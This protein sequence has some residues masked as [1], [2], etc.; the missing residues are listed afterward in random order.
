[1]LIKIEN[2]PIGSLPRSL[3]LIQSINDFRNNIIDYPTLVNKCNCEIKKTFFELLGSKQNVV[4]DGELSKIS[5]IGYPLFKSNQVDGDGHVDMEKK[6]GVCIPFKDGH[7]RNIPLLNGKNLPFKYAKFAGDFVK[8]SRPVL[9][10]GIKYKQAVISPSAI[11]LIYPPYGIDDYP[12]EDF[13]NDLINESETDIRSCFAYGADIVQLDATELRLSLLLDP[14]GTLFQSLLDVINKVLSRFS[15]EELANIGIHTCKGGDQGSPHSEMV[16]L[17]EIIPKLL[18]LKCSR[19]Y[20]ELVSE[21]NKD[22]ILQSVADNIKENQKVFF[23]VT[24]I[25]QSVESIDEIY[26]TILQISEKLPIDQF[27]ITDSCGF[28]PFYDDQ[29]CSL[30]IALEKMKN[31]TEAVEKFE[32]LIS[33]E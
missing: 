23:G 26:N 5:F 22:Q 19:F 29:S 14:S 8:E 16:D 11:S 6:N 2:E 32:N 20:I 1:M 25:S 21:P 12:R 31:R 27:G 24:K 28:S 4:T 10:E 9:P 13:I 33:K 7:T 3:E 17:V 15:A 30:E 18:T